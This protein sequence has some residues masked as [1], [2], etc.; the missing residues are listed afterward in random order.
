MAANPIGFHAERKRRVLEKEVRLIDGQI[1]CRFMPRVRFLFN[2]SLPF[3][4]PPSVSV[5]LFDTLTSRGLKKQ[6]NPAVEEEG[7]WNNQR[8]GRKER[9]RSEERRGMRQ[10]RGLAVSA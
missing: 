9:G 6:K 3:S 8:R 4:P 1:L 10:K 5:A 7:W 2:R